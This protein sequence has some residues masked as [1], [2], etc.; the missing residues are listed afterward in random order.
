MLPKGTRAAA[1][2]ARE[3]V[4]PPGSKFKVLDVK[5]RGGVTHVTM[6]HIPPQR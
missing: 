1:G 2:S 4:L 5:Q 3:L 6:E